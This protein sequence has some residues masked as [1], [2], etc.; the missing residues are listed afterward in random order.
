VFA[1]AG[2][3]VFTPNPRGSTGFGQKF[4]DEISG[5]WGG[6]AYTDI[7][8][9]V[10]HVVST[11]SFIDKDRIGGAGASYGGYMANWIQGHNNDKRFQFKV[12]V[13]HD[14]VYNLTSMY[15]GTEELWF[16]D[17][18]FKGT[19]W[20]NPAMYEKWSPHMFVKNFK[21]P[22]LVIHNELD[23]RV[24]VTEGIQLFTALQRQGVESKLL[25]FPDEGHWV[26]KP[27]NSEYWYNTVL[28]WIGKY[29]KPNS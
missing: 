16:T 25:Y 28:G 10:A 13:S 27:Q 12:L 2:Y 15:G 3:V 22:M 17:W 9:G 7:M 18:E 11:N 14:G 4:I 1:S 5:D 8:N 6:K 23:Y 29:L 21:T 24:P 26:L 19:P 20:T